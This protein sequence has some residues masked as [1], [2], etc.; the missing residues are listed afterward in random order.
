M[1]KKSASRFHAERMAANVGAPRFGTQ[2]DEIAF[3]GLT[4]PVSWSPV[5][6]L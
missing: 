3:S 5:G 6:L 2:F 1:R 4:H